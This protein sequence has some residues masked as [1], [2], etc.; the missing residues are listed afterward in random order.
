MLVPPYGTGAGAGNGSAGIGTFPVPNGPTALT[1]VFTHPLSLSQAGSQYSPPVF[2]HPLSLSQVGPQYS[3]LVLT[4]PPSMSQVGP[5]Y[6]PPVLTH[7]PCP[8]RAHSTKNSSKQKIRRSTRSRNESP[9]EE[10][11]QKSVE[12]DGKDGGNSKMVFSGPKTSGET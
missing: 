5:Q 3:P 9:H 8:N 6:S 12:T 10:N 2:T 4:H 1:P 7:P 11:R